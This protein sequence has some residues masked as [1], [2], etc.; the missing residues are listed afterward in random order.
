MQKSTL[1]IKKP[2]YIDFYI[3][4]TSLFFSVVLFLIGVFLYYN[5]SFIWRLDGIPLHGTNLI[6]SGRWLRNIIRNLFGGGVALPT[7]NLQYGLGIDTHEALSIWYSDIFN[8]LGSLITTERTVE[9]VYPGIIILR[10]YFAGVALSVYGHYRKATH[11]SLLMGSLTYA[12]SGYAFYLGFRHPY[13]ISA[14]V[15]LPLLLYGIEKIIQE[16]KYGVFILT[17][18]L[19]TS[20]S[21]YFLYINTFFV[22]PY[23]VIRYFIYSKKRKVLEFIS[24]FFR[25]AVSFL[26]GVALA[27]PFVIPRVYALS[28]SAR[29]TSYI[30]TPSLLDYGD[31]HLIKFFYYLFLPSQNL[32]YWIALGV[33]VLFA[34]CFV[35]LLSKWRNRKT[36]P[37][38]IT[39]LLTTIALIFPIFGYLLNGL[40]SV[41]NRWS[42]AFSLVVA[43]VITGY[44]PHLL[45]L[46]RKQILVTSGISLVY[47]AAYLVANVNGKAVTWFGAFS[48]LLVGIA[49]A[50][51]NLPVLRK[52]IKLG[53]IVLTATVMCSILG[54]CFLTFA[55]PGMDYKSEF[56]D[57]GKFMSDMRKS[58]ASAIKKVKDNSFYRVAR[59][60]A[61]ISEANLSLIDWF[62]GITSAYGV[63]D[64]QYIDLFTNLENVDLFNMNVFYGFGN[65]AALNFLNNVK[66]LCRYSN[67]R[68]PIPDNYELYK[69]TEVQGREVNIYKSQY[70]VPLGYAY[71]MYARISELEN[72]NP[73]DYQN[74]LLFSVALED[75]DVARVEPSIQKAKLRDTIT[76]FSDLEYNWSNVEAK[77]DGTMYQNKGVLELIVPEDSTGPSYLR[78]KDF[79]I[80]DKGFIIWQTIVK[81]GPYVSQFAILS[82]TNLYSVG[83]RN[84]TIYLGED[85]SKGE[86]ITVS[87]PREGTF[88]LGSVDLISEKVGLYE[89]GAQSRQEHVLENV[90]IIG[91]RISGTFSAPSDK[92]LVLAIPHSK[93]WTARVDGAEATLMRANGIHTA[94]LLPAGAHSIEL[95]Y[96]T[97]YLRESI[98]ISCVALLMLIFVYLV[99][100]VYC[101]RKV[102]RAV[103]A[104]V[105][106]E[107]TE[108]QHA[109]AESK[110]R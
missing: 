84:Y 87:L 33:P 34:F 43:W 25:S 56:V 54:V 21:Y 96:R 70:S 90:E 23:A 28:R 24:L 106:G 10:M 40:T 47:A 19:S 5:K 53:R 93:G 55:E 69:K 57:R 37:L 71:D 86:K 95:T 31:G 8:F 32:G 67:D 62:Y 44:A 68:S 88:C 52:R 35:A 2:R 80:Q 104:K 42:Y 49:I 78:L 64:S 46:S 39:V 75:A 85:L 98:L 76:V 79:E 101:L 38:I 45:K 3:K 65:R 58:P 26:A 16:N 110:H 92:I 103:K 9:Y 50:F 12:C 61:Y 82:P 29:G 51:V 89:K 107:I 108:D 20:F 60:N 100:K 91:D 48:F 13:F 18:F 105:T 109:D 81:R 97:P 7:M 22:L 99:R 66:Y 14:V 74:N 83:Q 36:R 30:A 27:A 94:L 59:S 4:Y 15:Y 17:V 77:P 11:W 1:M 63:R 102:S 72:M 73:V 41:G 6:Y